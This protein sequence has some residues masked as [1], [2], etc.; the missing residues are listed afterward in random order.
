ME[1]AVPDRPTTRDEVTQL[2]EDFNTLTRILAV[3]AE[4][5][6]EESTP[7]GRLKHWI[8][9]HWWQVLVA[10]GVL[11]TTGLQIRDKWN[12]IDTFQVEAIEHHA[13]DAKALEDHVVEEAK[14]RDDMKGV[15]LDTRIGIDEHIGQ[16]Q[17][18]MRALHRKDED[19]PVVQPTPV[20]NK[21][22]EQVNRERAASKTFGSL[23]TP[24]RKQ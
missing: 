14:A 24:P 1:G 23:P 20:L 10:F 19:K 16:M 21:Y 8:S 11:V 2:R 13:A 15:V 17:R 12:A 22:R 6:A 9:D 5:R 4:R 7:K 3:D 18:E